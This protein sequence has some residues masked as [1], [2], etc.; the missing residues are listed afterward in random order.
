MGA[1]VSGSYNTGNV[2]IAYLLFHIKEKRA[3]TETI[4]NALFHGINS[5]DY[6]KKLIIAK[7]FKFKLNEYS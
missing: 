5:K 4:G 3:G 2:L 6:L 1:L 7:K